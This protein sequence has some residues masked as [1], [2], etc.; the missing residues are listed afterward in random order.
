MQAVR[1]RARF[2]LE[3]EWLLYVLKKKLEMYDT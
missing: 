1:R 3:P 2:W